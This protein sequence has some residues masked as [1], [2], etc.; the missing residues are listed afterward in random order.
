MG[1]KDVPWTCILE[2]FSELKTSVPYVFAHAQ[3]RCSERQPHFGPHLDMIGVLHKV[4]LGVG[5]LCNYALRAFGCFEGL[6]AL[7]PLLC[8]NPTKKGL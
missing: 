8:A 6:L 2:Q 3:G 4:G 1:P 7:M 5:I